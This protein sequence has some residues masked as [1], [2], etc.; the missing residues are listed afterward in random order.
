[1]ISWPTNS[2]TRSIIP[3]IAGN[4]D[5]AAQSVSNILTDWGKATTQLNR[6][7]DHTLNTRY[8]LLRRFLPLAQYFCTAIKKNLLFMKLR[9]E[10][11]CACYKT[12]YLISCF[13]FFLLNKLRVKS[14]FQHVRERVQRRSSLHA[15]TYPKV[16]KT[17]RCSKHSLT[18][19]AYIQLRKI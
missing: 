19:V 7:D 10:I 16:D 15:Q 17:T 18:S 1:M 3:L 8:P 9:A 4:Q 2:F 6:Q 14:W 5:Q 13:A 11:R 12:G